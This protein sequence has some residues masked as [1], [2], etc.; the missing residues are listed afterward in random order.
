MTIMSRRRYWRSSTNS[1][2]TPE[3]VVVQLSRRP[4]LAEVAQPSVTEAGDA[5][6]TV[7]PSP[8]PLPASADDSEP[9]GHPSVAKPSVEEPD[10]EEPARPDLWGAG[11][12]NDPGLP[13]RPLLRCPFS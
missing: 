9:L 6:E 4:H 2:A 10:A 1:G 13:D 5:V 11:V 12:G 7:P 3:P 8:G